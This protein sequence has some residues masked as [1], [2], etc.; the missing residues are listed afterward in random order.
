MLLILG[1]PGW[2]TEVEAAPNESSGAGR[3]GGVDAGTDSY[4]AFA[5]PDAA[6]PDRV[7]DRAQAAARADQ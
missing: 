1:K 4:E 7:A 2:Q 6:K 3:G 5:Q